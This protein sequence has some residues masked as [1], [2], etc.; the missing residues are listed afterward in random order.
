MRRATPAIIFVD[1][2]AE[3][4]VML[5]DGQNGDNEEISHHPF[6]VDGGENFA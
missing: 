2:T 3:F 6:G 4:S 1:L 5:V